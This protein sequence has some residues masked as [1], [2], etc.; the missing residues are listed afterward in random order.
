MQNSLESMNIKIST[1]IS[2]LVGKTGTAIV[3]AICHT[4]KGIPP[5]SGNEKMIIKT[6]QKKAGS[7]VLPRLS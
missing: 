5:A 1:V 3:K 4:P 7:S 2:D 6:F